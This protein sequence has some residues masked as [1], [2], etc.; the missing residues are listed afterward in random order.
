MASKF[1]YLALVRRDEVVE[2]FKNGIIHPA[3]S[4][5]FT[6]CINDLPQ[7]SGE[8]EK[9][10]S[11][12]PVIEYSIHYF[13]LYAETERQIKPLKNGLHIQNLKAIIPLDEESAQMGLSL[14]PP[15]RLA[16]PMFVQNYRAYKEKFAIE[17]AKKGIANIE[18]IF[19]F[20]DLSNSI[21]NRDKNKKFT[22]KESLPNLVSI[23]LDETGE[24]LPKTIWEYLICYSRNQTYPKGIR[25]A[26]LDTLSVVKNHKKGRVI[27]Q[28]QKQT[29]TGK[30]IAEFENASYNAL[31]ECVGA[32]TDFI[33]AANEA[34]PDFWKIAPLYFMLLDILTNVSEDGSTVIGKQI[35]EFVS[36]VVNSY[37][38]AHL[39]P[40]LLMLG[41]TLGQSSTYK[42]LYAVKK[43]ELP[44]LLT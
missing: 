43:D 5:T 25:G 13:L 11:Q 3:S 26:F 23:V 22:I 20:D 15:V 30:A 7:Q 29:T 2:L 32:S 40:A 14:I 10:F 24:K 34:Y 44:F 16:P 35:R 39:A 6:G 42:M 36:S 18:Q 1:K 9:V 12:K 19:G 38:K 27:F 31:I 21:K 4:I 28:D 41:I 37:N 8:V 17:N 33:A